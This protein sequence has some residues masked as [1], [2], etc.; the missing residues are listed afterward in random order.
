MALNSITIKKLNRKR[1]AQE[2]AAAMKKPIVLP[3]YYEVHS[4]ILNYRTGAWISQ[5]P[6]DIFTTKANAL[7]EIRWRR[8]HPSDNQNALYYVRRYRHGSQVKIT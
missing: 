7:E 5:D 4:G 3:F 1:Q 2:E 8:N 6:V